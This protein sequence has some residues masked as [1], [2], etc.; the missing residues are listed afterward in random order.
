MRFLFLIPIL[1]CF[2]WWV[3][4]RANDWTIEQ[5]KKGFMYIIGFS[6]FIGAFFTLML[7]VT[8]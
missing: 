2:A 6:L 3:Y 4:L 7:F 1:L 5:G 8:N